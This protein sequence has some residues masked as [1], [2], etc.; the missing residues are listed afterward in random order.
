MKKE[1]PAYSAIDI[2]KQACIIQQ[3]QLAEEFGKKRVDQHDPGI[4]GIYHEGSFLNI[5]FR[6]LGFWKSVLCRPGGS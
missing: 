2:C 6:G 3:T 4:A 5:F 1:N